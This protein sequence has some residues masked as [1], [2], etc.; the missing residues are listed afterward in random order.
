VTTAL[1]AFA[2]DRRLRIAWRGL[3]VLALGYLVYRWALLLPDQGGIW[4]V[5]ARTYWSAPLSDPYPGPQ[6]GLPGAYV[7]SPAFLQ[8]VTPLRLLPWDVFHAL[9]IGLGFVALAYLVGPVGGALAITLLPFVYRDLFVGNIHLMMAAAIVIG[10]RWPATWPF[11]ILTKVTPGI[12]LA[13]FVIRGQWRRLA[14]ACGLTA[15]IAAVS[16]AIG[17]DL[18]FEWVERLRGGGGTAGDTYMLVL[19]VR[20]GIAAT[21]VYVGALI[22]RAWL[23]PVAITMA[24]P[25]IWPD[26]LAILLA[27]F[28]LVG[29][30]PQSDA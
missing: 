16:F 30:P 28:R 18:W 22:N 13:W 27:S 11:L 12:G 20:V 17:P 5:D 26:S 8:A 21:L 3:T 1:R 10:F 29:H 2:E 7:Y 14:I 23:V 9:W 19:V 24:L 4:A 15:A 25:I 6:V